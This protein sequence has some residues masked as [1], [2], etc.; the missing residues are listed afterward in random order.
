[1]ASLLAAVPGLHLLCYVVHLYP[2][3]LINEVAKPCFLD[4]GPLF[5]CSVLIWPATKQGDAVKLQGY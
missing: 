2:F 4:K 5:W 1:M 3:A